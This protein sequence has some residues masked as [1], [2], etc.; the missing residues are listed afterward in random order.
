MEHQL[1]NLSMKEGQKIN[2]YVGSIVSPDKLLAMAIAHSLTSSIVVSL[3][4]SRMKSPALE[5]PYPQWL[6]HL[7][8]NHQCQVLEVQV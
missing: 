8:P 4:E 1:D 6:L 5:S 2:K 3:I 7:S